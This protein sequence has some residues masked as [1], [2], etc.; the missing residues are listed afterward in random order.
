MKH[1]SKVE[2]IADMLETIMADSSM[3][4]SK[5]MYK[6]FLSYKQL[7]EYVPLLLQNELIRH[8]EKDRTFMITDK[9][10]YY[11]EMYNNLPEF[12]GIAR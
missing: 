11:L 10:L 8:G 5:I 2:I 12:V 3:S 1:R 4:S 9:G 7:K 6:A